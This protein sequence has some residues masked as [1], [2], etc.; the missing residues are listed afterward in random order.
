MEQ[1]AG[2]APLILVFALM[3]FLIIRPQSKKAKEHQLM[4]AS[5][6]KGDRILMNGGLIGNIAS[7]SDSE[8]EL[9]V[10]PKTLVTVSRAMVAMKI[11]KEPKVPVKTDAKAQA[12]NEPKKKF[13]QS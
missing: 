9:E 10:A 13:W 2:M 4:L 3:Y 1:I 6:N 11:V 12:A 8:I 7:I 5:L